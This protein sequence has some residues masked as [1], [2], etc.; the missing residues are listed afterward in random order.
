[1]KKLAIVAGSMLAFAPALALADQ[2]QQ[3]QTTQERTQT[4]QQKTQAQQQQQQTQQTQQKSQDI[5]S[6][7]LLPKDAVLVGSSESADIRTFPEQAAS[8]KVEKEGMVG[9]GGIDRVWT[10]QQ[11]YHK[12]VSAFDQNLKGEDITSLARTTTKSST[13]W[14]LRMPDGNIANVVVRNTQPTTIEAVQASAV[15]GSMTDQL[16]APSSKTKKGE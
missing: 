2:P 11:P 1:M 3:T 10:T 7:R 9:V 4:T 12:A 15:V 14:N 5:A 8:T 6:R 16:P 13:A